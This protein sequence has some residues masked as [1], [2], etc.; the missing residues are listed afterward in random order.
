MNSPSTVA[1]I[2]GGPAGLI[3]AERLS[4]AGLAVTVYDRMP[5]LGRRLLMAGRGGL[6]LTHSEP[7][8][9]FVGR[10]GAAADWVTPM[11]ARFTPADLTA[12]A[13]GLGQPTFI[14]SSG[15][16]F[17]KALKASPLLRAWL[18]RL[19]DQG[20]DLRPRHDWLGWDAAGDLQFRDG[21]GA[22][23]TA[24]PDATLL[25]LGGASWPRLGADGGWAPLLRKRGV[26]VA[27]LKPANC[28][29]HADWSP[30]F[31]ERFQGQ[32]LKGV[33]A[34]FAGHEARGEVMITAKGLEGGAIYALGAALRE[35]IEAGDPARVTLDLR[36]DET[37]ARLA[38]RLGG[39][40]PGDSLSNRLRRALNLS[41]A[42]IGLLREGHGVQLPAEPQALAA[43]VKA[44]PITLTSPFPI[45]R[46]ISS[47]GGIA[48]AALDDKLMLRALPNVYAAG[49]ML[50]W[51]APTGG[52]L[53]QACFATGVAAAAA[54]ING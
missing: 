49:E 36:P 17:P 8:D 12:W 10:Y 22:G 46:A 52:Y 44:V 11:L 20:V 38:E 18:A 7:F 42:A 25:A 26:E 34:L 4:A 14:G 54:I 16:V 21:A 13:E 1:V 47:A 32:A 37:V 35:S 33:A 3:A 50:D 51:E 53:L 6:N 2:G 28:G 5:S 15:R 27:A 39:G 24:R 43:A 45:D 29:F 40:R 30:I 23:V 41:P 48:R 9:R 31:A 19:S